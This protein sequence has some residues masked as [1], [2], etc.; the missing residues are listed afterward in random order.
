MRVIHLY[1]REYKQ[2]ARKYLEATFDKWRI[3]E[4]QPRRETQDRILHCVPRLLSPVKQFTILSFYIPEY[5]RK[6]IDASKVHNLAI[7]AIPRAFADAANKCRETK[8]NLDWFVRGVF[9]EDEIAAFA[10]VVRYTSLD[11]LHRSYS[12][13]CLDLAAA[14][15]H[16]AEVDAKITMRYR[17]EE[18]GG[19]IEL[20]G[21]VPTLPASAFDMPSVPALVVRH[22][23]QYERLL[24][25]HHCDM[26]V[27]QEAQVVRHQVAQLDLSILE[28]A[29]AS[30][31]R[32]ESME[33]NFE[34]RGAGGT[35]EGTV[36][37]KNLT[38]LKAQ[39]YGRMVA[40]I[41]CTLG[42]VAGIGA[43]FTSKD[44]RGLAVC[45]IWVVFAVVP[46]VWSWV[47]EKHREV[48][49]YE[50]G[51]STRFAKVQG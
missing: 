21:V 15:T 26:L 12:A 5:M 39:L 34:V 25:D 14:T 40:A 51:Q 49:D 16:L 6:L 48:S 45:G 27:K 9:S 47:M 3:G 2:G 13:V 8:P 19:V 50:R 11:R 4:V 37:R 23:E 33:S 41:I 18:L 1:E 17:L 22:R 46:A 28:N 38:V 43:A 10:D 29:I 35:F 36:C 42:L 44:W 24:I 20:G 30:V 32:A 31:S 7:D